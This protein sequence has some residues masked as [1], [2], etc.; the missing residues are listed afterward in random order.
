MRIRHRLALQFTLLSGI[1]LLII[2]ALVYLLSAQ[3]V[4]Q[5][6]YRQLEDRALITA[7]VHLEKDELTK[8][9]FREIQK[10]YMQSIPDERSN[11]YN[12]NNQPVFVE[13]SVN[14]QPDVL[15]TIR[16]QQLH[17]FVYEG[18]AA[19][20]LYYKDN[21]GNYVI[22]VTARNIA[23]VEQ[24]IHLAWILAATFSLGLLLIF[25]IGQWYAKRSLMPI[26]RINR[27]VKS[28]RASNLHLRVHRGR[29]K[30]EIDELASNFNELLERLEKSFATQQSFVSNA[31]HEL[32]T[33]LTAIITE[34]EVVLQRDR[35]NAEYLQTLRSVLNESEKLQAITDGLLE[36]TKADA[37]EWYAHR[38]DIRL[39]ELLWELKAEWQERYPA[40]HLDV[41]FGKMPEDAAALVVSGNRQLLALAIRNIIKN[42]F[43]F[44]GLQPVKC[45][46][47]CDNGYILIAIADTGVGI[48]EEDME[49]IFLPLFRADN[50]RVFPGFGIG[51]SLSQ[52]IIHAHGGLVTVESKPG[53][54]STFN[55]SFT[56]SAGI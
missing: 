29:N 38:E 41:E 8:K 40:Q 20:G 3:Y 32:R 7:Q 9:K 12:E 17:R 21:Q 47:E 25:L 52:K 16:Q 54:G 14:I 39:D 31:S 10:K 1:I 56:I 6:F 45:R 30:D 24:L 51:L 23:G 4:R 22:V 44:S 48:E 5:V 13:S 43:K 35:N 55:I 37:G 28:I 33:P 50:A 34:L 36:L 42:A 27:E 46:L 18:Q 26:N 15:Q 11:I 53:I 49:R 2:F 19:V